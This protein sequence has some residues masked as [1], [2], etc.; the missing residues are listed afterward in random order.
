M[1][2]VEQRSWIMEQIFELC[3]SDKNL[4][5][6]GSSHSEQY[7]RYELQLAHFELLVSLEHLKHR[8]KHST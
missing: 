2:K 6:T 8:L 7:K 4:P 1:I 3:K 5:F